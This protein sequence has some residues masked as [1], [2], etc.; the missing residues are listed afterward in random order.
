MDELTLREE[1][2][3]GEDSTRQ[4]KR[5]INDADAIGREIVAF[6]NAGGGCIY[7]G[8]E[9]D[10]S[11]SGVPLV[12]TDRINQLL[13]NAATNNVLPPCGILTEN[14][15]TSD[16]MV[17]VATISE[18]PDKPYQAKD[19][20]FYVKR[21][22]D[23]RKVTNRSEI[24]RMFQTSKLVHADAYPVAG[25]D[26]ATD[27]DL[28]AFREFF[29]VKYPRE[30]FPGNA[31]DQLRILHACKIAD[32]QE[33]TTAGVLMFGNAPERILP[34]FLVKAVWFKGKDRS[35]NEYYDFRNLDGTLRRQFEDGMAFFRR[36]NSRVQASD[37]FNA[38]ALPEVPEIVFE[39]LFVNALV[40]RDYFI[41]DCVKLF[42]FDDRIEIR[43]PGTLPNSL[44]VEEMRRGQRRERNP[45]VLSFAKEVINFRG[46]G[47]GVMRALEEKP[48]IL[49]VNDT[50]AGEFIATIPLR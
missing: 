29:A 37:S 8:V 27:L 14:V 20:F 15:A 9:D 16:G 22:A 34:S 47:S 1:L 36:W 26:W 17:I 45:V 6:L 38:P 2:L 31:A 48:D 39:E 42:F 5:Q 43:S 13:A 21:G 30:D 18:G 49:L 33:V 32:E 46:I 44:T 7:I 25:T 3:K 24:L 40:H 4:F 12:E 23:K 19:G 41:Q 10:G 11:I 35:G 50:E 28:A